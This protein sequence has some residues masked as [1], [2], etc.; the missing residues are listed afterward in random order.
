[1][2]SN[3]E[4]GVNS[5]KGGG[6]PLPDSTRSYFEP[7]FGAD[8]SQVRVHTDSKAADTA[9]SINAKAFTKGK[10]VV[11]GSG[12]YS[13]GTS[14]GKHLLAH[15]LTHVVQQGNG[16]KEMPHSPKGVQSKIDTENNLNS[17]FLAG[18]PNLKIVYEGKALLR[19]GSKGSSVK[20]V[21]ILLMK[22]GYDLPKKGADGIFGVETNAAIK[23]FQS[24]NGA[25]SDGIVGPTTIGL[26]DKAE[27]A[28]PVE[29]SEYETP[30]VDD[31][32]EVLGE[33]H[34]DIG[35]DVDYAIEQN[36]I[37]NRLLGFKD[38]IEWPEPIGSAAF[39]C[40]VAR[41]QKENDLEVDGMMGPN[42]WRI[43]GAELG[44]DTDAEQAR[45]SIKRGGKTHTWTIDREGFVKKGVEKVR[46]LLSEVGV[47]PSRETQLIKL[48]KQRFEVLR[49]EYTAT[50]I[51][52]ITVT[53]VINIQ[54][55]ASSVDINITST[56]TEADE[57]KAAMEDFAEKHGIS[58]SQVIWVEG[59]GP[60]FGWELVSDVM[61]VRDTPIEW[62]KERIWEELVKGTKFIVYGLKEMRNTQWYRKRWDYYFN[63]VAVNAILGV[64]PQDMPLNTPIGKIAD[65]ILDSGQ[66]VNVDKPTMEMYLRKTKRLADR[67]AIYELILQ[68]RP[69]AKN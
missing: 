63:L 14:S 56:F 17:P 57:R 18:D 16:T 10:D 23:A 45:W 7:R 26:L 38:R 59:K 22:L 11:F 27:V 58:I 34:L 28:Q 36:K 3:I 33:S 2:T 68:Q 39:A 30:K 21:Q 67:D 8:F 41:F 64:V 32:C 24:D 60:D 49:N 43:R 47:H 40:R 29:K 31:V 42:T 46:A 35:I 37:Y 54:S 6:Q 65:M 4:S 1:V 13:P 15:E 52:K 50:N 5:L 69:Q 19:E 12:Q 9:K 53:V 44:I 66:K 51:T 25:V 61:H 20:K 55:G 48:A 62:T